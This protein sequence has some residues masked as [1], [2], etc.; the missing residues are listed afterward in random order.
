MGLVSGCATTRYQGPTNARSADFQVATSEALS[1]AL[2][3]MNT[4]PYRGRTVFVEVFSL[5][6]KSTRESSEESFIRSSIEGVLRSAGVVVASSS[7]VGGDGADIR[8][9]VRARAIGVNKTRRDLAFIY[10][11]ET[12][13][14][15][16]DLHLA[17]FDTA[18]STIVHSEDLMGAVHYK[19]VYWLYMI[20]PFGS[21]K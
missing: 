14:G 2:E 10:Y 7:D 1:R 20:G 16:A 11:S 17:A 12:T 21:V 6:E 18:T 8:L 3:S 15:V 19:Q 5:T 4:E 13:S 9:S